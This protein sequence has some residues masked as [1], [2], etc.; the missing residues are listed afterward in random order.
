MIP[1]LWAAECYTSQW[2]GHAQAAGTRRPSVDDLSG[3][4]AYDA[5]ELLSLPL[6]C[7][8]DL[9]R[10]SGGGGV[11]QRHAAVHAARG[12]SP[13]RGPLR[14]ARVGMHLPA[15][16]YPERALVR[17]RG[18][19]RGDTGGS[20]QGAAGAQGASGRTLNSAAQRLELVAR[21]CE[22]TLSRMK[23]ILLQTLHPRPP[24]MYLGRSPADP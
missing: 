13:L 16:G 21:G 22:R 10:S 2:E 20:E 14:R 4:E 23:P 8:A 3:G 15:A 5:G 24:A 6:R 18:G 11:P 7:P 17:A 9:G 19:R 1:A 12:V